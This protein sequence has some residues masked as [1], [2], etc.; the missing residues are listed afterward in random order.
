[1]ESGTGST[2]SPRSRF[3]R[4]P[5]AGLALT[6]RDEEML[7]ELFLHRAMSRGQLQALYFGSA[8]RCNVRMRQLFDHGYVLRWYPEE[9]P[10]GA[11]AVYAV[12]SAS[13]PLVARRLAMTEEAVRVSL[14]RSPTPTY[15]AHTLAI[16]DFHIR[17]RQAVDVCPE[18]RLDLWLP[19]LRCRHEYEIRSAGGR[20]RP[21][22]FKPD[23]FLRIVT[24]SG[25]R[26]LFLEVDRGTVSARLFSAKM[27]SYTRY[28]ESGLYAEVYG[29]DPFDVLVATTGVRR[30]TH[31]RQLAY[32]RHNPAFLFAVTADVRAVGPLS[33]IWHAD[34]NI[35]GLTG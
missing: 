5:K 10:Y 3:E 18:V 24:P 22:V 27:D 15:L 6:G 31:L 16:V 8:S 9:A 34:A 17:L 14:R 26:N 13:V 25:Y 29:E 12:A 2:R 4:R 19:E 7:G 21:E 23:A 33:R 1:M 30:I 11:Q 35:V 32:G 20:W 28:R